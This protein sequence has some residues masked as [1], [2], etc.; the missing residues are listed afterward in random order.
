MTSVPLPEA[1]RPTSG[2]SLRPAA[3]AGALRTY[4]RLELH[5][6]L[7]D[8]RTLLFSLLVPPFLFLWVGASADNKATEI[9]PGTNLTAS[10]LVSVALFGAL[11]TA[12]SGGAGVAVERA[13]GWTRQLRLTPLSSW[14]YV[15]VKVL[16]SMA[17]GAVSVLGTFAA[18]WFGG[19]R[20]PGSAWVLCALIAWCGSL[21]FA[22]FGLLMGYLLPAESVL[23]LLNL[24]LAALSFAGGLFLPFDDGTVMA[25]VSRFMP[26][27]G[28][29]EL[30]RAPL[31]GGAFELFAVINVVAWAVIF[32]AGAA[33]R[34]RKDTAR[35]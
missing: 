11:L 4:L 32:F 8:R 34:F 26:T 1:T 3:R 25:E 2:T 18:G 23:K 19:A 6:M 9:G 5:R 24:L 31:G 22:A 16:A 27:Y 13:Q 14:A 15:L 12:S 17:V 10:L 33:W 30:A 29:A 7:R 20:M 35:V 28:L 21:V